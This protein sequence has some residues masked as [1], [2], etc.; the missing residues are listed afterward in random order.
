M[1][2]RALYMAVGFVAGMIAVGIARVVMAREPLEEEP[3]L[4]P[5]TQAELDELRRAALLLH[6]SQQPQVVYRAPGEHP[7]VN[8]WAWPRGWQ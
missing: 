6:L 5:E 1:I 8:T 3:D 2:A 7:E 4:D